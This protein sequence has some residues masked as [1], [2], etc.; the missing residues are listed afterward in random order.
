MTQPPTFVRRGG[1]G[2]NRIDIVIR[3]VNLEVVGITA[4]S[5][6][7]LII[8]IESLAEMLQVEAV[9]DNMEKSKEQNDPPHPLV[10]NNVVVEQAPGER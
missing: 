2:T 7:L 10:V 5:E 3:L 1:R 4:D 6:N 9:S 8:G